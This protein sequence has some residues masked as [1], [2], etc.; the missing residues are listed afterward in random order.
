[1]VTAHQLL[2]LV[3]TSFRPFTYV[4]REGTHVYLRT[5]RV[6]RLLRRPSEWAK[7]MSISEGDLAIA[8]GSLDLLAKRVLS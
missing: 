2:V 5:A 6:P 4:G 8:A 1:V 3:A 7:K